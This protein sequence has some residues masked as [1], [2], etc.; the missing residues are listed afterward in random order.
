[1]AP[2]VTVVEAAM[3]LHDFQE[4]EISGRQNKSS[5]ITCTCMCT[6]TIRYWQYHKTAILSVMHKYPSLSIDKALHIT[7][8]YMC[9]T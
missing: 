1:M 2:V 4:E 6:N 7:Y 9:I 3:A 8:M 5:V